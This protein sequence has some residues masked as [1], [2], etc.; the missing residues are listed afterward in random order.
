[1]TCLY[2]MLA[3]FILVVVHEYGHF[4]VARLLGVKVLRFSFGFGKVLARWHDTRGT[5]YVLSLLPL[6]GYVKMLDETEGPVNAEEKKLA[7]NNKSV[8]ARI[9]IV[10]AGPVFNFLFAFAAIW[11]VLILGVKSFAPIVGGVV[12]G[13]LMDKAGLKSQHEIISFGDKPIA[14]WRDFQ[15]T[16]MLNLG[17]AKPVALT[18]RPLTYDE[19]LTIDVPLNAWQPNAKGT[20]LLASIGI[21]PFIPKVPT[22]VGKIKSGSPAERA[23]LLVGDRIQQYNDV[24]LTDWL[25][26]VNFVKL[27]PNKKI[28]LLVE[29]SGK[30]RKLDVVIGSQ[31][32]QGRR[33]GFLGVFSMPV[34]WPAN[35]LR[36]HREGPLDALGSAFTQT[37]ELTNATFALIGK[38]ITGKLSVHHISGPV[39][40]ARSAGESAESGL[41]YYVYFLAL[42]SISLGVLNLLPIPLLD[43]GHLLFY[44]IEIIRNRPLSDKTKSFG[45]YIGFALLVSLMLLALGNDLSRL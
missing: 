34:K 29:R 15:Y 37:M 23:G 30:S 11:L 3:L 35:W 26:L 33:V 45:M 22:L 2:F 43:G 38:L 20:D 27:N 17:K 18:M 5:E 4:L 41:A 16:F 19:T 24:P 8:W 42:V 31:E 9:A 39:G 25:T 28:A 36:V 40:I 12:P 6:G 14:S 44:L 32:L 21:V 10:L 1:M 7:F 13:S